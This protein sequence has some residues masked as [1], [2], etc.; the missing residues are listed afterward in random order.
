MRS[1]EGRG[2][3]KGKKWDQGRQGSL[4]LSQGFWVK[5]DFLTGNTAWVRLSSGC[6][7]TAGMQTRLKVNPR[8][9]SM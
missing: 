6:L 9:K 3:W 5:A 7:A 1:G 4:T 8:A 2:D